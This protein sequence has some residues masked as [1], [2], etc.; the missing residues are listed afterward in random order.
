MDKVA[1]N[2]EMVALDVNARL[3]QSHSGLGSLL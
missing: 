1:E 3:Q 2:P